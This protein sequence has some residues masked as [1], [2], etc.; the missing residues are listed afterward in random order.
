[1]IIRRKNPPFFCGRF[2][3]K[4]CIAASGNAP[5]ELH[6]FIPPLTRQTPGKQG[7]SVRLFKKGQHI[8]HPPCRCQ[9]YWQARH[10]VPHNAA[11]PSK[12]MGCLP[13]ASLTRKQ[14]IWVP[15]LLFRSFLPA[16]NAPSLVGE[17]LPPSPQERTLNVRLRDG[18]SLNYCRLVRINGIEISED[19]RQKRS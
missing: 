5:W 14:G 16:H 4:V 8:G 19:Q 15:I 10:V 3:Q 11:K 12:Q 18:T 17:Y 6:F 7:I 13:Y 9:F 1:V 2:S